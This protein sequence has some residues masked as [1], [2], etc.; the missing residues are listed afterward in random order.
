MSLPWVSRLAFDQVVDERDR[1]R[2]RVDKLTDDLTRVGRAKQGLRETPKPVKKREKPEPMPPGIV[3]LISGFS[4]QA[5]RTNLE[6]ECRAMR[7]DGTP[8]SEIEILLDQ[9]ILGDA[10]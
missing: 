4:M 3:D 10:P 8:W 5:V 7:M 1:L 2:T 9:K 6:R